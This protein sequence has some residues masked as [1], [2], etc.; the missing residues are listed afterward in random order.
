[1]LMQQ[2]RLVNYRSQMLRSGRSAGRGAI[3]IRPI[4]P[5]K[6]SQRSRRSRIRPVYT[7]TRR[8]RKVK[9]GDIYG[10]QVRTTHIGCGAR[11]LDVP[12]RIEI[13]I[14]LNAIGIYAF[15][16]PAGETYTAG[17]APSGASK[18][19]AAIKD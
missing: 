15:R 17:E 8:D 6:S 12:R 18:I 9:C 1:M 7:H 13:R 5:G 16:L 14:S 3:Y 11:A 19:P 10:R 4:V 2:P